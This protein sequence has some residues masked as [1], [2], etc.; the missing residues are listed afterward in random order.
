LAPLDDYLDDM[1]IFSDDASS[2]SSSS[3]TSSMPY[4]PIIDGTYCGDLQKN[5][6]RAYPK[7]KAGSFEKCLDLF[8]R[9]MSLST[10]T[11]PSTATTAT[12]TSTSRVVE[13]QVSRL[14]LEIKNSS[15]EIKRLQSSLKELNEIENLLPSQLATINFDIDAL[16]KRGQMV[17]DEIN[18]AKTQYKSAEREL[19][20]LQSVPFFRERRPAGPVGSA[21]PGGSGQLPTLF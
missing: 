10:S 9:Q 12:R 15:E 16:K 4:D 19:Y 21:R 5:W 18:K 17:R 2:S 13:D 20:Q 14:S 1:F 7:G 3:M 6:E 11:P 8:N